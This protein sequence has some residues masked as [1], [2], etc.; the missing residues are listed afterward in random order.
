MRR[1][2]AEKTFVIVGAGIGGLATAV[3]LARAGVKPIVCERAPE[4]TDIGGAITIRSNATRILNS[5][6]VL[7]S[8]LKCSSTLSSAAVYSHSGQL[9]RR[10]TLPT[11]GTP[12]IVIRRTDLQMAL[13]EHLRRY[14]HDLRLGYDFDRYEQDEERVTG[15]FA[16]GR[17]VD[18]HVL[19]GSDGINSGVRTQLV[20]KEPTSYRGYVQWRFLAADRHPI[21]CPHEKQEWWGSGLRFGVSPLGQTGMA[22]Y[23]SVNSADA[24][25]RGPSNIREYFLSLF[26]NWTNPILE[27]ISEVVPEKLVWNP[28][29]D[30]RWIPTWG[31]RRVTLLGDAA[32]PFTPD[33]GLGGALAIE[34]A[35]EIQRCFD[36]I[37]D[38]V[39]ALRTYEARRREKA[40][41]IN[42]RS[43]LTG[44]MT[45][46]ANPLLIAARTLLVSS[47]P[48]YLWER[49][50]RQT[51][52]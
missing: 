37:E 24:D 30:R 35:E 9:F 12:T 6:G 38:L 31:D 17:R 16:N 18:G 13:L 50:M 32:H 15:V 52:I 14:P 41:Q 7:P 26:K 5:L 10:W 29:A 48:D 36:E 22:W 40:R 4:L 47:Y 42:S 21:V 20:G 11:L 51:Y 46:W 43:R 2:R 23:I 25:W 3:S 33:L 49:R 39:E 1:D 28:I 34:D 44:D 19:I 27:I 45:Q 8:V